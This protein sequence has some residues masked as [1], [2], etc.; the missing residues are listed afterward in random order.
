MDQAVIRELRPPA[1]DGPGDAGIPTK[2]AAEENFPVGSWLLPAALRPHIAA[3]YAFAR[4][5]DD[6]ADDPRRTA[7]AKIAELD[8][9]EAALRGKACPAA[10]DDDLR[11]AMR[12]RVS[13]IEAEVP[14]THG[15]ELCIAFRQ[16]AVK[17]RY[18]N[19]AE[20]MEYC[21]YSAAPV[22]RFLLDLHGES[23]ATWPASD[24]LCA[25]LQVINHLQDCKKDFLEM[26]RVYLPLDW[27]DA[28]GA[29]TEHLAG[30]QATPALRAVLDRALDGIEDLNAQARALP[31]L[32]RNRRMRMEAA[33]IVAI[34]HRLARLLRERDPIAERVAL[35]GFD[36]LACLIG[37]IWRALW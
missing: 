22:G 5:V 18:R 20:L 11:K 7:G 2:S 6:I 37:G 1:T 17:P 12:L 26:D 15:A 30:A 27:L 36:K 32:I 34:A 10:R 35:S 19:W 28:A 31:A 23:D 3:Y 13:M 33:V 8:A 4:A 25:S 14:I 24:A 16:D 21:R 29:G 9:M